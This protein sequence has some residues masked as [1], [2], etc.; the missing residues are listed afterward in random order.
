MSTPQTADQ[1]GF[2]VTG[3]TLPA[4]APSYVPRQADSDLFDALSRGEFCYVLTS[5]Q[6]GKSSLM[7]RTAMR[8]RQDDV[9]VLA[10]DLTALGQNVEVEQWYAGLLSHVGQR[11][12]LEDDLDDFWFAHE[13][14]GPLQRWMDALHEVVMER[15][16]G[17]LV[18]FIDEIDV[19]QS[20]PFSTGEF[21]AAIRE[22]YTRR[23]ED[24][25]YQRLTFCLIG[26]ATPSDLIDD[27]LTTPFNVGTRIDLADFQAGEAESLAEG[28]GRERSIARRLVGRILHWTGGHPYLTQRLCRTIAEDTSVSSN[29]DV[30][31][32]C[33]GLFFSDRA[34]E[35]DDN[36][37]FV[38]NQMLH[39]DTDHAGLLNLYEQ[40]RRGKSVRYD[41]TDPFVNILR[42]AG[43]VRVDG[44][45]LSVRNRIYEH[46]FDRQWSRENM[47]DPELRRQRTAF[48]RGIARTA[49]AAAV[50]VLAMGALVVVAITEARRAD[51][52]TAD[53]LTLAAT[54]QI[55]RGIQLLES[56]NATGLME[57]AAAYK[58]APPSSQVGAS[59]RRLW[60]GW[61][62]G[63]EGRISNIWGS[64][65]ATVTAVSPDGAL[66]AEAGRDGVVRVRIVES[67]IDVADFLDHGRVVRRMRFSPDGSLLAASSRGATHIWHV[68]TGD[69]AI[70]SV[71]RGLTVGFSSDGSKIAI[72][73]RQ[74]EVWDLAA[75]EQV[76]GPTQ[77]GLTTFAVAFSP[78]DSLIAAASEDTNVH[79]W[80]ARTLE[81]MPPLIPHDAI[82]I[83]LAFSPDGRFL[84]TGST[85]GRARV[86]D[87]A[88]RAQVGRVLNHPHAVDEVAWSAD[89]SL[90]ATATHDHAS[91]WDADTLQQLGMSATSGSGISALQFAPDAESLTIS[92]KV[93]AHVWRTT[94]GGDGAAVT[95]HKGLVYAVAV[96]AD[97]KLLAS[98]GYDSKVHVTRADTRELAY[99]PLKCA[100][101]VYGVSFSPD[102]RLLATADIT[103]AVTLWDAAGSA[104]GWI[105]T[106][107]A[108]AWDVD[109]S[110]DGRLIA[111]CGEDNVA[112]I[113]DVDS[114]AELVA[115]LRHN[116]NVTG[117]A[118]SGDG[119]LLAT[120]AGDGVSIWQTSTGARVGDRLPHSTAGPSVAFSPDGARLAIATYDGYI[121][122][123]DV[124]SHTQVGPQIRHPWV[125]KVEYSADGHLLAS[126]SVSDAEA[127]LWDVE[128]GL[129][130][131]APMRH[132]RAAG[133]VALAHD[134][135]WLATA[136]DDGTARIWSI[137]SVVDAAADMTALSELALG[138]RRDARGRVQPIPEAA[139]RQLRAR[140]SGDAPQP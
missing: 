66:L 39:R 35:Q 72:A 140:A 109:F 125:W 119:S 78:D 7:V 138:L 21:F 70:P 3:G 25:S 128:T 84:L 49:A 64:H 22:C 87:V 53:A 85:D 135:S 13:H 113:W 46:V 139:W 134:G 68:R 17:S 9:T 30:D 15:V 123:W 104:T 91:V 26:V 5:R 101:P 89:G 106:H 11:L 108:A 73:D 57:L 94:A 82:V 77:S 88:T 20:L 32:L 103:G 95:R 122:F 40:V 10:L 120:A 76:G 112:K 118:F 4:D 126:A 42:L 80:N 117:V 114:G 79:L 111:T 98:A 75:A 12:D 48:R 131:G 63:Y 28:L 81:E 38:R 19:V 99:P 43:I 31:R 2:Y 115:P 14:L 105:V 90:L 6:M 137:P 37:L 1:Y 62:A 50:V 69:L 130:Y 116:S 58:T 52:A 83:A 100:G 23:S 96:S 8:L 44:G 54:T 97:G 24:V 121:Q 59:A 107:D 136:C 36:L 34:Q 55:E 67:D 110:S 65:D 127:Q 47:P 27:P 92:S 102:S 74:L 86:W 41:E 60:S 93:G 56:G 132:P 18:I 33:E 133:G 124:S 61:Y 45:V 16:E 71:P 129:R 29:A 51:N